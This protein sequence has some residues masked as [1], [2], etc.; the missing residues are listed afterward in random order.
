MQRSLKLKIANLEKI[1]SRLRRCGLHG[2]GLESWCLHGQ[3]DP[4][5]NQKSSFSITYRYMASCY[6]NQEGASCVCIFISASMLLRRHSVRRSVP[7][8]A[9]H[10]HCRRHRQPLFAAPVPLPPSERRVAARSRS[11]GRRREPHP[12]SLL[13]L[14]GRRRRRPLGPPP[15]KNLHFRFASQPPKMDNLV[16]DQ[17]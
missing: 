2:H 3:L 17:I 7:R 13:S 15:A 16:W 12:R 14:P 9:F 4:G 10:R 5:P 6:Q 8:S 1:T 11:D